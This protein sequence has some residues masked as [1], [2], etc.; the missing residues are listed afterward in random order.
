MM[1]VGVRRYPAPPVNVGEIMRYARTGE[2]DAETE[3][4][5]RALLSV[6]E[7][8]LEFLVTYTVLNFEADADLCKIA[9]VSFT[10]S[11]LAKC[12]KKCKRI[13][14]FA[15]SVGPKIDRLIK[16]YELQSLRD[17]LL[18]DA[19]G[20]ERVEALCDAFQAEMSLEYG[21]LT[22]RF[23]PGYGD[24]GLEIQNDIFRLLS[25]ERSIGLTLGKG[26]LMS[27]SKSVTALIGI[28]N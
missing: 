17:A 13:I 4:R 28:V 23:S 9:D 25:P 27:P 5:I 8:E 11:G 21:K 19:I 10:S 14:V 15:A 1:G 20:S 18:L 22:P 12:M 6:S 2:L 3:D 7:C 24:L 16:K 26:L